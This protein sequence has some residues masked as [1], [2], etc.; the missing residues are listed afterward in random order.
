ML[1]YPSLISHFLALPSLFLSKKVAFIA[2]LSV[3]L[4]L[5]LQMRLGSVP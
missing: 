2:I 3:T 5:Q 1:I 4:W